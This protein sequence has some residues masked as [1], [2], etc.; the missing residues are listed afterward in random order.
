MQTGLGSGAG[1]RG[2]EPDDWR[3][4][5]TELMTNTTRYALAAVIAAV[6]CF[7]LACTSQHKPG[8]TPTMPVQYQVGPL[9]SGKFTP[10]AL[11]AGNFGEIV[12]TGQGN[13]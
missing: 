13:E 7:Q 12:E 8:G 2:L 10:L 11:E 4:G 1:S 6:L 5:N 9:V 3:T